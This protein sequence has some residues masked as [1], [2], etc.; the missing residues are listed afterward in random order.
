MTSEGAAR[1]QSHS[2]NRYV[3]YHVAHSRPR[4]RARAD[5]FHESKVFPCFG[6]HNE[7]DSEA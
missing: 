6:S 1:V 7:T 4:V 5:F 3:V 2:E